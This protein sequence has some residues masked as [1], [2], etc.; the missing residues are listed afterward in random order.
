MTRSIQDDQSRLTDLRVDNVYIYKRLDGV[1]GSD[2]WKLWVSSNLRNSVLYRAHDPCDSAHLGM[3]RMAQNLKQFFFWPG[4]ITQIHSYISNCPTCK[5]TKDANLVL[6][7]PMGRPMTS[8]RP[9][10]KL[11][12]DLLGPYPRSKEGNIGVLIIVD[13]LSK[14]HFLQPL[15]KFISDKICD[16]LLRYVFYTFGVPESILTDN[17]SQFK[18]GQFKAFL[19]RHISVPRSTLHRL[20]PL[21]GSTVLSYVRRSRPHQLG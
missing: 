15:K 17:G 20:T 19:T 5:S 4:M 2:S 13:H 9:F 6:R 12:M 18:S 7:P 1:E 10:Q 11:Y 14:F 8:D 21:R 16:Y 3:G